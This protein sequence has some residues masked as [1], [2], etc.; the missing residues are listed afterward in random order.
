MNRMLALSGVLLLA[1]MAQASKVVPLS[2]DE[3]LRQASA[4]CRGTVL[5]VESFRIAANG[6]IHTRTAVRVEEAIKGR[7][8][9]V[10]TLVHRG[11]RIGREGED[12]GLSPKFTVGEERLFFLGRRSDGSLFALQGAASVP[13]LAR[14]GGNLSP[15]DD[16][17]LRETRTHAR[18]QMGADVTDQAALDRG[19]G[20]FTAVNVAASP[21]STTTNLL[22]DGNQ[23]APRFTAPD[24]GEAI[25]YLVDADALPSGISLTQAL[26]A[27][28][29]ALGA[30][31]NV[32]TLCYVFEGVQ[33]F[34]TAAANVAVND[35]R[36]RIQLHDLYGFIP[37]PSVL[38]K[39]GRG[40]SFSPP[41]V[42]T[43][44][45]GGKVG[46]NEFHRTGRGYVV[47]KH[48]AASVRNL[49]TLT[50]VLC[51]EIGHT[52]SLGHSSE[53]SAETWADWREAMM[54]FQAHADGR[55][56]TLG[57]YD[58][59]V[60][61]QMYPKGNTP[62]YTYDRVMDIVTA[63]FDSPNVSGVNEIE[64]RGYDLQLATLTRQTA[65]SSTPEFS[66]VGDRLKYL[67]A[68]F[69]ATSPIDPASSGYYD[70]IYHR[71]S[72][73]TNAS[74]FASVRTLWF[75]PDTYPEFPDDSDG[76]PDDWMEANFGSPD[77]NDGSN[78][79][80]AD[81][82]DGDGFTNLREFLVGS[83]PKNTGSS[84]R[85]L[86]IDA[87]SFQFQAKP[88]EVYEVYGSTDLVNWQR[89]GNPI[90]P[91]SA[92]GVAAGY[93]PAAGSRFLRVLKVP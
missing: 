42:A 18:Q 45:S 39:G 1:P 63:P 81:D 20:S 52:L 78:R 46:N 66:V 62:P 29:Q 8:P 25:P 55:G 26:T 57:A 92:V 83:D 64:M 69:S 23:V 75:R 88:Y 44:G 27:V 60:V 22:A 41:D 80:P 38:G 56:A 13:R 19:I 84:L 86:S 89:V 11:G 71:Y 58:P 61:G 16:A 85:I 77:P 68:D 90:R 40:F 82:F 28:Q 72:D 4:V 53:N 35:G 36:L 54:F 33:S 2:G 24:R 51:H 93:F 9:E 34:G 65:G 79:E 59:R 47:L 12:D 67:P 50:E 91:T 37:E 3:R 48:T 31:T 6:G 15:A 21:T 17:L 76:V 5:A 10:V 32:T 43:W 7:F 87:A 49:A 14:A 30:W 73:G 74:P 70:I